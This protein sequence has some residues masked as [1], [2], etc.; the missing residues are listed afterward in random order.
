MVEAL[1]RFLQPSHLSF[2]YKR[3]RPSET[4]FHLPLPLKHWEQGSINFF[5]ILSAMIRG[6][7]LQRQSLRHVLLSN[8]ITTPELSNVAKLLKERLMRCLVSA[9]A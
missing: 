6:I 9:V 2:D 1:P 3:I 5:D 7:D 8:E 4:H